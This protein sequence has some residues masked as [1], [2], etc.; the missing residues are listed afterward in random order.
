M[1]AMIF[2]AGLG[3]RLKP[4][5]NDKPKAL[6]E[7][8][9]KT[10]LERCINYLKKFG[11]NEVVI[12]VHHF[13][14][15][16]IEFLRANNNLGITIHISDESE[17]LLD[18][19]GGLLKA[20]SLLGG[21]EPILIINVDI[22]TN[23]NLHSLLEHHSKNHVLATLVVRERQSS[24]YLL[25]DEENYLTGWMNSKI[26]E[27]K[28]VGSQLPKSYKMFAF[29]GIQIIQ[30]ELL[31]L[32]TE[33]GKFSIIDLYLRLAENNKVLAFLDKDSVWLD[34]GKY[35]DLQKAEK[36]TRNL[37]KQ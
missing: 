27:M 30:P 14:S 7:V 37:S 10:L 36:L 34:L 13:S 22:L 16:I 18:T 8:D 21:E 29:S 9:G 11:I 35:A 5:T 3:T 23:L 28:F 33:C 6:V 12:N 4:L 32:I 24:R 2:A 26:N 15:Q 25:F 20:R 19:G 31:H 17:K 1:K